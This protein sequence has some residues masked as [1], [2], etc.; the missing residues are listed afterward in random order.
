[1]PR[2]GDE[3]K[4]LRRTITIVDHLYVSLN[5]TGFDWSSAKSMHKRNAEAFWKGVKI[6]VMR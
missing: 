5:G 3:R 4:L 6:E 2:Y 1:L